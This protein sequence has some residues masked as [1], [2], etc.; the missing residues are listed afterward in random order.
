M[1]YYIDNLYITDDK[2]AI[3]EHCQEVK[4][5]LEQ[6]YWAEGRSVETIRISIKNS[7]SYAVFDSNNDCLIAFARVITDYATMYYLTDV[8]VDINYR[9]KGIGKILLDWIVGNEEVLDVK[10][11]MLTTRDAEDLY[12]KYGF[13]E[14]EESC[15]VKLYS[16]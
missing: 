8:I 9:R 6:S 10:Y 11:G 13:R 3:L 2:N 7:L 4:A 1:T 16:T 12:K 5:L 14:C 15:M